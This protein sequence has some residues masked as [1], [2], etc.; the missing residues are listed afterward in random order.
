[1]P[2]EAAKEGFAHREGRAR[3]FYRQGS[4]VKAG[5]DARL[6]LEIVTTRNF[7]ESYSGQFRDHLSELTV[8]RDI[9][10]DNAIAAEAQSSAKNITIAPSIIDPESPLGIALQ[11]IA[12]CA[13]FHEAQFR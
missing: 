1:M 11:D 12:S 3:T 10:D 2:W 4:W 6:G 7:K 9:S 5:Q 13:Y 8:I